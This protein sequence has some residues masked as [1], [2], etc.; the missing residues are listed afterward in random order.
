MTYKEFKNTEIY[1]MADV[2]EVY[3][4]NSAYEFDFNFP[5]EELEKMEVVKFVSD[6]S[7]YV[8][9]TLKS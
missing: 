8:S 6:G 2:L 9:V 1:L 7:G 3:L 4:A 5:E